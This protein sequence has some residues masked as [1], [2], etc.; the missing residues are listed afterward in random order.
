MENNKIKL[1]IMKKIIPIIYGMA[2]IAALVI[3]CFTFKLSAFVG[4]LF[5]FMALA[6]VAIAFIV[7]TQED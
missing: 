7:A 2:A 3:G 4:S 1:G 5:A 6:F